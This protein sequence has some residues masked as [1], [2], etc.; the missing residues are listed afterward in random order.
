M[1]LTILLYFPSEF[2]YS[3]YRAIG[4]IAVIHIFCSDNSYYFNSMTKCST[5]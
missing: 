3:Q 4:S 1:Q 2:P 5:I